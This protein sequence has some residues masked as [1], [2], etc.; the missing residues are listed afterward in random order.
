MDLADTLHHVIIGFSDG[1]TVPFALTAG[2]S[3][4]GS[5]RLVVIGGLAELFS[6]MISMG[7]GA[8]LAAVTERDRSRQER[9]L[10]GQV[11]LYALLRDCYAISP[12]VARALV[13]DLGQDHDVRC[14]RLRDDLIHQRDHDPSR[15]RP[16]L[17]GFTMGASYFIGG[18]IPMIP[19]FFVAR[20]RDAL[21]I[22]VIVTVAVLLV[23][24]YVKDYLAIR[25]HRAGCWGAF[26]TLV[27]GVVAAGTSYAIV[28]ALD[29]AGDSLSILD[30]S[31]SV[32]SVK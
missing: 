28:R 19:Y 26:L 29:A 24:G 13:N 2:L 16:C 10:A 17:A 21:C 15:I 31:R 14:Q 25:N 9:Q 30:S 18:L 6:G 23:F 1:L 7:L 8:Y 12:S 27:I 3:S 4:L 32:L 22:S 5:T 20:V 11:D